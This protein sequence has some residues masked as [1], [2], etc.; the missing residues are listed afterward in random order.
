MCVYL[1]LDPGGVF[2]PQ[3]LFFLKW[4]FHRNASITDNILT[5]RRE[6]KWTND[7][8]QALRKRIKLEL[9]SEWDHRHI[10]K[11]WLEMSTIS[12]KSLKG[13]TQRSKFCSCLTPISFAFRW[14][15]VI[16]ILIIQ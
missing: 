11:Y 3:R 5:I 1:S 12:F 15:E 13:F 10:L 4:T 8:Q 9:V 7:R 2:C 14:W 6:N 16:V